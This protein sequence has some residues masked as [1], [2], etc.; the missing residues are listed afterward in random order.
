MEKLVVGAQKNVTHSSKNAVEEINDRINFRSSMFQNGNIIKCNHGL[1]DAIIM[2][3]Q[4]REK[5]EILQHN[6]V[7]DNLLC[8]VLMGLSRCQILNYASE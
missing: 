5:R 4:T 8:S 2:P 3:C 1:F 6:S 7:F